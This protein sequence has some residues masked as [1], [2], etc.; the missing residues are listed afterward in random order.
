M[1]KK[2]FI[3]NGMARCGKDTFAVLLNEIIP[4]LKFS[5]IDI[6]KEIAQLCGWNGLSKT[7]KDRK[8]LSDLK[9]L[10]IEYSNLPFKSVEEKVNEFLRDNEHSV[11]LIDIR[12]PEEIEKIRFAFNAKTI[13]IENNRVK[14]IS[15][16]LS[17]KSVFDYN[18]DYIIEN[19][20]TLDEFKNKIYDFACTE[21]LNE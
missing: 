7:E 12:E 13:L 11:L 17:D 10:T 20:G 4:T 21:I 14:N 16:N 5:S 8:F 18:Y 6:I 9:Q 19:N 1:I 15:S 2:I 3:T